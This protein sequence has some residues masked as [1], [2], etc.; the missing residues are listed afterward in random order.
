MRLDELP[1][2]VLYM[3]NNYLNIRCRISYIIN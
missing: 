3:I 2:D 1:D